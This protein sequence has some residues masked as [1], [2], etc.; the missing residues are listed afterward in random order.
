MGEVYLARHP[1]LPRQ[2]ALKVL[3]AG[4]AADGEFQERFRRE[5]DAAAT[6]FHPNIVGVHDRGEFEGRLWIAMDYIEGTDAGQLTK[7]LFRQGMPAQLVSAIVTAIAAALDYAH[8]RG[9]LHR[10]VKPA[11]I[12]LTEPGEGE[13]RILLGDFGIVRQL[14]DVSDLTATNFTMG[15]VTYSAPEQL[16]GGDLDGRADQY[17][18]AAT[19]YYL[20]TGMPPFSH[21]NPVAVI[22]QHLTSTPPKLSGRWP[23]LAGLDD[24]LTTALAKNPADRYDRCRDFAT[25]FRDA[26]AGSTQTGQRT[27]AAPTRATRTHTSAAP[28]AK[29]GSQFAATPYSGNSA[30]QAPTQAA[31]A[32]RPVNSADPFGGP[33]KPSRGKVIAL[34]AAATAVILTALIAVRMA[35]SHHAAVP[36]SQTPQSVQP[37]PRTGP[38]TSPVEAL[39]ISPTDY[40]PGPD[41][42]YQVLD[43]SMFSSP[44]HSG[45]VTPCD[46]LLHPDFNNNG[47]VRRMAKFDPPDGGAAQ[48][49]FEVQ[50]YM[51]AVPDWGTDFEEVL[52]E[53]PQT[54]VSDSQSIERFNFSPVEIPGVDG[55]HQS[56]AQKMVKDFKSGQPS[57][58]NTG[59][60]LVGVV[61][62]ISLRVVAVTAQPEPDIEALDR[63]LVGLYN[64]QSQ[65]ILTSP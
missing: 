53:C 55:Q 38:V 2:D 34:G 11:N 40:S 45:G 21:S 59:H 39:L 10:D 61:R 7:A 50:L 56:Y 41:Y 23:E 3:P 19:A 43:M 58:F 30:D 25:A 27:V 44:T 4:T 16:M 8:Q 24:V 62:G 22:S 47:L 5:A 15:T 9:L 18:L 14:G 35:T 46:R 31:P 64:A 48:P 1:R 60:I 49:D 26:V 57:R 37:T 33:P 12:L 54:S 65:R 42:R 36:T 63:N 13:Q 29:S 32:S 6:L 52:R 20:L 51:E 28:F 17:A